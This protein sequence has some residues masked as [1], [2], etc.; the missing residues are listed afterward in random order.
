MR[1]CAWCIYGTEVASAES[2][3]LSAVLGHNSAACS[4]E[5]V[6]HPERSPRAKGYSRRYNSQGMID[7]EAMIFALGLH[8]VPSTHYAGLG[9]RH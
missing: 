4:N 6:S 7:M 3:Y 5:W 8:S 2:K 1:A 9:L